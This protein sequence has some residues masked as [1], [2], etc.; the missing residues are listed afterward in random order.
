MVNI[1]INSYKLSLTKAKEIL[2]CSSSYDEFAG[3]LLLQCRLFALK[4]RTGQTSSAHKV[5]AKSKL[6][7]K[8]LSKSSVDFEN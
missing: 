1:W 6:F 2:S 4:G 5:I 8:S 3:S 7:I